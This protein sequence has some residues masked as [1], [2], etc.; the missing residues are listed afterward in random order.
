MPPPSLLQAD[1]HTHAHYYSKSSHAASFNIHTRPLPFEARPRAVSLG[2][3]RACLA[4]QGSFAKPAAQVPQYMTAC[5]LQRVYL[6]AAREQEKVKERGELLLKATRGDD[7]CR[8]CAASSPAIHC[9]SYW[10][11]G[12]G[13]AR[14][15]PGLKPKP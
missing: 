8:A 11:V 1:T 14:A 7:T 3:C 9:R 2:R 4:V 12:A 5:M 6:E 10:Q 13:K 15:D